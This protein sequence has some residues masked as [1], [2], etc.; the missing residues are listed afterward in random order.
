MNEKPK[1]DS[2][3]R[4]RQLLVTKNIDL[5]PL[6]IAYKEALVK[7]TGLCIETCLTAFCWYAELEENCPPTEDWLY[8]FHKGDSRINRIPQQAR[9]RE[10]YWKKEI[11]KW[12]KTE[13][14]AQK[15]E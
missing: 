13:N 11:E 15:E 14:E 1:F 8:K 12:K 5:P 7:K 4:G 3:G 10:E 6:A 9:S 2:F